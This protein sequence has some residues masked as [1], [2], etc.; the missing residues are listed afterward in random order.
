[1]KEKNDIC[2]FFLLEYDEYI[3]GS[4]FIRSKATYLK[5]NILLKLNVNW[6]FLISHNK[7]NCNM[8]KID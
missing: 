2:L 3:Q 7:H 1:M 8:P 6:P 5:E 4:T